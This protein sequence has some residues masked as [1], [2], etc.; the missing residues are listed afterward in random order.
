MWLIFSAVICRRYIFGDLSNVSARIK[1]SEETTHYTLIKGK[2]AT[3]EP[4]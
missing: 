1:Y 2:E 4:L 3:V